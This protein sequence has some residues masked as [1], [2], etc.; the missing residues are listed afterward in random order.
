[1]R[2][3]GFKQKSPPT[4]AIIINT[5]TGPVSVKQRINN[6][7]KK[8][9]LRIDI[10]TGEP[11]VTVPKGI[12]QKQVV[13]FVT[14][15]R[16]WIY[17]Q[18][19]KTLQSHIGNGDIALLQGHQHRLIY[20]G[21]PPRVITLTDQNHEKTISVGGPEDQAGKRLEKWFKQEARAKLNEACD[22]YSKLLGVEYNKVSIGDMKSRWGSCS[23]QKILRFNWRLIM[24]PPEILQYVAAHEVCHLLEMN[25]SDRFWSHVNSCM[26][27]YYS[28]RKWLRTS[29]QDL[30]SVKFLT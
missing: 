5:E 9:I 4:D 17:D 11:I 19:T 1:M 10:K 7:A 6:Q 20:T 21:T 24:A 30:M 8:L 16:D 14:K 25:H 3:A 27:D 29:G 23:S 15:H 13:Q 22:H 28:H 18:Y 12:S 2:F 26:P